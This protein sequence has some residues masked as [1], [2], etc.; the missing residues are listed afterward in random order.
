MAGALDAAGQRIDQAGPVGKIED[1]LDRY[2]VDQPW[3][4]AD[5]LAASGLRRE[6]L[7]SVLEETGEPWLN[8][9]NDT[10]FLETGETLFSSERTGFR[11]LYVVPADGGTPSSS[12]STCSQRSNW[13]LAAVCCPASA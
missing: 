12:A 11:H 7:E 5:Q 1:L 13:R 3:E 6:D 8:L 2:E 10:R 4:L 9:S